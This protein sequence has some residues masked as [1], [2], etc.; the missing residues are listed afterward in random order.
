[1]S[2]TIA[3]SPTIQTRT[4][5]SQRAVSARYRGT[6]KAV[7]PERCRSAGGVVK[8]DSP[9]RLGSAPSAP[10]ERRAA[11]QD[12]DLGRRR[13]RILTVVP[14]VALLDD[15]AI[16]I[17]AQ[18]GHPPQV[19]GAAIAEPGLCVPRHGSL[20]AVH[21]RGAELGLGRLLLREHAR[22]VAGLRIVERMLLPE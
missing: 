3:G 4:P 10:D 13:S 16:G 20:I 9:A 12:S 15:Q 6:A 17:E 11:C 1:R 7:T 21:D 14:V 2:A 19:L 22:D 18:Q 8:R 5:S